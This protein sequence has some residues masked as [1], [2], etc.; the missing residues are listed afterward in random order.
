MYTLPPAVDVYWK[1]FGVPAAQIPDG[2]VGTRGL[3]FLQKNERRVGLVFHN[4]G[5]GAANSVFFSDKEFGF[6][7]AMPFEQND[8]VFNVPWPPRNDLYLW[9]TAG[10]APQ[11]SYVEF[12]Y[13]PQRQGVDGQGI[14]SNV[15]HG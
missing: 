3:L 6:A 11:F 2:A 13:Q 14:R 15:Q 9:K 5:A 10:G 4:E 12:V 7:D 8:G 1:G